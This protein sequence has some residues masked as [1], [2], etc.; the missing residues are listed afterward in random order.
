MA[1]FYG[2]RDPGTKLDGV[3]LAPVTAKTSKTGPRHVVRHTITI[4]PGDACC[5]HDEF[6]FF[7]PLQA[8]KFRVVTPIDLLAQQTYY[9]DVPRA[10]LK[11]K[12][13]KLRSTEITLT[14]PESA[15]KL[16]YQDVEHDETD[17]TTLRTLSTVE[18]QHKALATLEFAVGK[19]G[20]V[21]GGR[22]Y[23]KVLPWGTRAGDEVKVTMVVPAKWPEPVPVRAYTQLSSS[24]MHGL[25]GDLI[26]PG[27]PPPPA[28][29]PRRPTPPRAA[30]RR[31]RPPHAAHRRPAPAAAPHRQGL[32]RPRDRRLGARHHGAH[33][34]AAA[35][36]QDRRHA[37]R[38][39]ARDPPQAR[40]GAARV[41]GRRV[42]P[43][44][45]RRHPPPGGAPAATR[46]LRV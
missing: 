31:L 15:T 32:H 35:R 11:E 13:M 37:R 38:R 1:P 27:A 46:R 2:C 22:F 20:T 16:E 26:P 5:A 24:T 34:A 7:W 36:R 40:G 8:R 23:S 14:V 17:A 42:G 19:E 10:A 3:K 21:R 44:R 30:S 18:D 28:A 25:L 33:P 4:A 39:Q 29:D 9:I 45:G 6:A 12:R 43:R 41:D